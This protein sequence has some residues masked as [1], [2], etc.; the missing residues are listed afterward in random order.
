MTRN[1]NYQTR[2]I[3]LKYR[4][5]G[6]S[7]RL[8][9]FFSSSFGRIT[10]IARGVRRPG[11]RLGGSLE[12]LNFAQVSLARGRLFE[13]VS[14]SVIIKSFNRIKSDLNRVALALYLAELTDSFADDWSPNQKLYDL[15]ELTLSSLDKV[16]YSEYLIH[17]FELKLLKFVGYDPEFG[18]CVECRENLLPATYPFAPD[19]GGVVCSD[20]Q[21]DI[22]YY[23]MYIS[24]GT[25]KILR[26]LQ[27]LE[28]DEA[29]LSG[30]SLPQQ[31]LAE[32]S[33]ILRNYL[34]FI[35]ERQ[36]KST[37]FLDQVTQM[38]LNGTNTP[39]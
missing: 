25:M 29:L 11:S 6:E 37:S 32:V 12:P 10:G 26:Y 8:I 39:L 1:R 15:L 4:P 13:T 20:C 24:L 21:T 5:M 9:T 33:N 30:V 16:E 27:R 36:L 28:D 23:P 7:D 31:P 35:A 17:F 22:E 18:E 38:P 14:E 2:A 19:M 34:R 3:V